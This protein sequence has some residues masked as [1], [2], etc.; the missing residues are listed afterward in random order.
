MMWIDMD[1]DAWYIF[2]VWGLSTVNM[3]INPR[4]QKFTRH[5]YRSERSSCE[6]GTTVSLRAR[7]YASVCPPWS[8][9][10]QYDKDLCPIKLCGLQDLQPVVLS[11]R[12]VIYVLR[13]TLYSLQSAACSLQS[14]ICSLQSANVRHRRFSG[15]DDFF[16]PQ[17]CHFSLKNSSVFSTKN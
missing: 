6:K 3:L 5:P 16:F 11:Q 7:N 15:L 4:Q 10:F 2:T 12:L 9:S 14:V 13:S 17:V 8:S 1:I